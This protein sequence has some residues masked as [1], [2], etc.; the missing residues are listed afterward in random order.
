MADISRELAAILAAIY[1]RDV[2]GSIHDA[3]KKTND[4]TEVALLAGTEIDSP[5]S[6]TTGY[7][8]GSLYMNTDHW[9]L[10]QCQGTEPDD[11][12]W[13]DLGQFGGQ[14]GTSVVSIT[15][16]GVDPLNPNV[17]IYKI[18]YSD[19]APSY[20]YVTN[21]IDG[22]HGSVWYKGTALTGSGSVQGFPGVATDMYLN[23]STGGIYQC[24]RTGDGTSTSTGALWD[25][26]MT[27]GGGGGSVTY[28][29]DLDDV[30]LFSEQV[31][32]KLRYEQRTVSG[33]TKNVWTN[34]PDDMWTDPVVCA[35]DDYTKTIT[36]PDATRAYDA[37]FECPDGVQSPEVLNLYPASSTTVTVVFRP[38]TAAQ[39]GTGNQCKL[40]LRGLA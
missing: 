26:V 19:I 8:N 3:L 9:N 27:L 1:G 6:P 7:F 29:E 16:D 23:S 21:G 20:F 22:T 32:E 15:K 35:E 25:Y 4:A 11:L 33:V 36:V 10:W 40:K 12:A 13:V 38:V 2:R 37:Y 34:V 30:A 17:D 18:T 39:A 5:T 14:D 28:L 31:H 24:T